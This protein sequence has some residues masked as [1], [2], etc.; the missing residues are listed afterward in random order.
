MPQNQHYISKC[1]TRPW[2]SNGKLYYFDFITKKIESKTSK[3][4]FA[5]MDLW[6]PKLERIFH[7]RFE[8]K[9][10]SEILHFLKGL[11]T[12]SEAIPFRHIL[13]MHF[14]NAMRGMKAHYDI[15][16]IEK[17][18]LLTNKQLDEEIADFLRTH[19]IVRIPID[20]AYRLF[21]SESG[22]F[23]IPLIMRS[24]NEMN[25]GFVIP[26]STSIAFGLFPIDYNRDKFLEIVKECDS[27]FVNLSVGVS[28]SRLVIHPDLVK[29]EPNLEKKILVARCENKKFAQLV[30]KSSKHLQDRI[31]KAL[32]YIN[33]SRLS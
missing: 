25:L 3:K 27:Y 5:K 18:S 17:L 31:D 11:P 29:N 14:F 28:S 19:L 4:L 7:N 24:T 9:L 2:E 20:P 16:K 1:L 6:S 23:S 21:F 22:F 13:I 26:L 32:Q 15:S 12:K 10:K 33:N 8:K 30:R